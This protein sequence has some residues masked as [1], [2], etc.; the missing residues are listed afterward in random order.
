MALW[1]AT[2]YG[3]LRSIFTHGLLVSY[4]TGEFPAVWAAAEDRMAWAVEHAAERH[5]WELTHMVALCVVPRI[6]KWRRN[7]SGLYY[8]LTDVPASSLSTVRPF[9][10]LAA[11]SWVFTRPSK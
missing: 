11:K 1:H 5:G 7:G 4:S 9:D 3:H 6:V 2:H 8:S 10:W